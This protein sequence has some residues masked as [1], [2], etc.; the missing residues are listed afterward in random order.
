MKIVK[1]VEHLRGE[2]KKC[3][4]D[5]TIYS[6]INVFI[7]YTILTTEFYCTHYLIKVCLIMLKLE[8]FIPYKNIWLLNHY[9]SSIHHLT[10]SANTHI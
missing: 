8:N 5:S 3:P 7:E 9:Y 2:L 10:Q 1:V 4:F 6:S